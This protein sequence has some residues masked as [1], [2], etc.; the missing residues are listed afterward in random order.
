MTI[1]PDAIIR[2][3][4]R[5]LA[6]TIDPFGRLIVRAPYSCSQERIFDF[7]R[8]KKSWILRKKSETMGAGIE[9]PPENLDGYT[10]L[11]LGKHCLIRLTEE[12][13]IRFCKGHTIDEL[14]LPKQNARAKLVRWLKENARRIFASV[15]EEKAHEMGVAYASASVSS[16]KSRWG[17]CSSED[18]IR[19]TFRLLYAPR[20]AIEYVVVHELAHVKHKN[21]SAAFWETVERYV[22]DWKKRRKW[23]KT[24]RL[25]MEIF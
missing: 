2:S 19:Y 24:H 11:L 17:S 15:T 3:G 4:R 14:F 16:A 20:E 10:F 22:P 6:I 8:E 12:K 21:H 25:L 18:K 9:L 13:S 5:T 1:Q 7:L 23:L